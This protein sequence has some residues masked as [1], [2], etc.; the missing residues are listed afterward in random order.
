MATSRDSRALLRY[1]D[2]SVTLTWPLLLQNS[3]ITRQV[4][5]TLI[6]RGIKSLLVFQA[7][8][9]FSFGDQ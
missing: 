5:N 9:P 6:V 1:F 3:G 4:L 7:P 2:F 8:R